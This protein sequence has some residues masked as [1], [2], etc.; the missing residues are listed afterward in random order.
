MWFS[1]WLANRNV[2]QA[3]TRGR[4]PS[5][6]RKRPSF[7]P[8]LEA[9][10][11]RW[12]PSTLTVTNTADSG[13]GSLRADIAAASSGDTIQFAIPATDAGYNPYTGFTIALASGELVINKNLTIQGPNQDPSA[14]NA[15]VTFWSY[16]SRVFEIDGTSTQVALSNLNLT[17]H[18]EAGG[19]A[20]TDAVDGQGG[21][22]W[23]DGILTLTACNLSN[24]Y[25]FVGLDLGGAIYNAGTLTVNNSTLSGNLAY[26][27]GGLGGAIYNAG[28]MSVNNST[29]SSNTAGSNP[30]MNSGIGPDLPGD[31]GAIYN[32]GTM[33]VTDSI[34]SG[35]YANSVSH[36]DSYGYGGGI[37]NALNAS[38]TVT[39]SSLSDNVALQEGGGI[40]NDGT[41]TLSGSTVTQNW[42]G[43]G[44]GGGIF[45]DQQGHLTIQS[46]SSITNNHPGDL[47]TITGV[48]KISKDSSVGTIFKG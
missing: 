14:P 28:T 30:T 24:N 26:A 15:P 39:G 3:G 18:G 13:P 34:L 9:L 7:R 44:S 35:N 43:Y 25:I 32:A 29:L 36:Y 8:R 2:S 1:S 37:F 4:T 27:Y 40:S 22:I 11:D 45:N 20:G 16:S 47:H 33:S 48:V 38:A 6:P 17:G 5:A 23:N 46:K 41:M 31:G 42:G 10:E 19:A 21:A 12:L